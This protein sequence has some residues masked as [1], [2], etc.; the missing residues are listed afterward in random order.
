MSWRRGYR[1]PGRR[2]R[3]TA[4]RVG[5]AVQER[6]L[7]SRLFRQ[8]LAS[9]AVLAVVLVMTALPFSVCQDFRIT[10]KDVLATDFDFA[11]LASQVPA[12]LAVEDWYPGFL[13]GRETP[14]VDDALPALWDDDLGS[15]LM[16]VE[17]EIAVWFGWY[18]LPGGADEF[19][20]GIDISADQ[21][22]E[23][24]AAAPGLVTAIYPDDEI[25]G[26][27]VEIT[28][29]GRWSTLYANCDEILVRE[30]DEVVAGQA[31][32]TVGR[33]GPGD[34]YHLHFELRAGGNPVDPT[35]RLGLSR[36]R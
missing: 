21:G 16:P 2:A 4:L 32:A 15:L 26:L 8:F 1:R 12:W 36:P 13:R 20:T 17:G 11:R 29:A 28:H 7:S 10:V 27:A 3:V 6:W 25:Y 5:T 19:H 35:A 30:G 31:I 18:Q 23:I 22:A 24:H 34:S 33:S 9:T 14:E